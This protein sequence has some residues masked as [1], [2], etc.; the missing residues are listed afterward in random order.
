MMV[1]LPLVRSDV[2]WAIV[3]GELGLCKRGVLYRYYNRETE[4]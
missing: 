1:S 3:E 2:G 4:W